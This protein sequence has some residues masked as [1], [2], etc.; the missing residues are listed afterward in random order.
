MEAEMEVAVRAVAERVA[1]VMEEVVKGVGLA[2]AAKGAVEM[3]AVVMEA[4]VMVAAW[5]AV[6]KAGV[7][8]VVEVKGEVDM[9]V[10]LGAAAM[11][12]AV[13]A[14]DM[15]EDCVVAWMAAAARAAVVTA[16]ARCLRT[17]RN[18]R[19]LCYDL[20]GN[21]LHHQR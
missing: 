3:E 1:G 15:L 2:V 6:G 12:A 13:M 14:A 19:T 7:G 21:R 10:G 20:Q 9:E 17:L 8:R 18:R 4:V 11:V 16:A 5:G